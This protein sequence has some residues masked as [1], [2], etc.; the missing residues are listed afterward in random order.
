M[1]ENKLS[2]YHRAPPVQINHVPHKESHLPPWP[3]QNMSIYLL[4]EWMITQKLVGEVDQLA[5]NVLS[6]KNFWLG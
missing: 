5:K 6:S 4:I 3:F 2:I 1:P